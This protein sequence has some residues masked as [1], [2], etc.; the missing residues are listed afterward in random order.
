M[1]GSGWRFPQQIRGVSK[2][3]P[4]RVQAATVTSTGGRSSGCS[5]GCLPIGPLLALPLPRLTWLVALILLAQS[6]QYLSN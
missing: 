5:H 1:A 2:E 4:Q 3:R 6:R